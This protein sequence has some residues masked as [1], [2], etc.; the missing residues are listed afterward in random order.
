MKP[1]MIDDCVINAIRNGKLTASNISFQ[2]IRSLCRASLSTISETEDDK[3]WR[4]LG[5]GRR[6]LATTSQLDKY[7]Y[8]YGP[9]IESQW[10]HV[11]GM[12]NLEPRPQ[13][14]LIDYGCGQGLSTALFLDNYNK[15]FINSIEKITLIEPS[16]IAI[17]RAKAILGCYSDKIEITT[18][19]KKFDIFNSAKVEGHT[20]GR[21]YH[22]FS[23]VLD[24]T[25]CDHLEVMKNTVCTSGE[26][27]ILAVSHDRNASGGSKQ[28]I[29]CKE[30]I[31]NN[32]S[33][34][35]FSIRESVIENFKCN[36][37]KND[38]IAFL[39]H[40]EVHDGSV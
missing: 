7:S 18:V 39:A 31:E 40:L 21:T 32:A 11:F 5:R 19:N 3:L 15:K 4:S 25:G 37:G 23:N 14:H 10:S 13:A 26:N 8:T 35:K 28:I 27:I 2:K 9:M 33:E 20:G 30:V 16:Q 29:E 36:N 17:E 1:P 6:I 38:A 24:I 12:L 22:L 34:K